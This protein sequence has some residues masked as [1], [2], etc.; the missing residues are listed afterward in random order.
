MAGGEGLPPATAD[1]EGVRG[2]TSPV[3]G[4][5]FCSW[6]RARGPLA[7]DSQASHWP[8]WAALGAPR[9]VDERELRPPRNPLTSLHGPERLSGVAV[10]T[11]FIYLFLCLALTVAHGKKRLFLPPL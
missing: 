1:A 5:G 9:G 11:G 7:E 10:N 4:S 2:G 3:F 8:A 6:N